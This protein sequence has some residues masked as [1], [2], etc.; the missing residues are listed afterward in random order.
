MI[1]EVS[2]WGQALVGG[3]AGAIVGAAVTLV[4][5]HQIL[6][7]D[8]K[9]ATDA[10]ASRRTDA[11][12]A[13]V[14]EFRHIYRMKD[15]SAVAGTQLPMPRDAY[16]MALPYFPTIPI[17]ERTRLFEAG[18]RVATYNAVA[19]SYNARSANHPESYTPSNDNKVRGLAEDAVSYT[20]QSV[21]DLEQLLG[22]PLDPMS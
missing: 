14:A 16:E 1:G 12:T 20:G 8:T 22:L 2:S 5:T 3:F 19:A 7:H 21:H 17:A 9:L 18:Y 11:L 13:V 4:A 6:R 15:R 10:S